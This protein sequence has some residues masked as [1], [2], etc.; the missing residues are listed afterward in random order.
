MTRL[1]QIVMTRFGVVLWVLTRNL[2]ERALDLVLQIRTQ[3]IADSAKNR[4]ALL[5]G[6]FGY[7]RRIL[8]AVMQ[9]LDRAHEER[10]AFPDVIADS[11]HIVECLALKFIDV[12]RPLP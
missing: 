5:L 1:L 7:R 3:L 11:N 4:N 8:E 12:L 9:P 6:S 10:A 2:P